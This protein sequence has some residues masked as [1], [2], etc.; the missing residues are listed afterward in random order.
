MENKI[1]LAAGNYRDVFMRGALV[2]GDHYAHAV[3]ASESLTGLHIL[4]GDSL[5]F[6]TSFSRDQIGPGTL[7]SVQTPHG[8]LVKRIYCGLRETVRLVSANPDFTDLVFSQ[9]E[10]EIMGPIIRIERDIFPA[11]GDQWSIKA[12]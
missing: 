8:L 6:L 3:Q 11:G 5:V 12:K 7:V 1:N 9:S 2:P 10:V 4:D